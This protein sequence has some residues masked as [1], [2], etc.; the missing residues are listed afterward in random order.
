MVPHVIGEG[1]RRRPRGCCVPVGPPGHPPDRI[2]GEG[3]HVRHAPGCGPV[4]HGGTLS[5]EAVPG[6]VG[7]RPEGDSGRG[8]S[9]GRQRSR[10]GHLLPR[11]RH[12]AG[13]RECEV[14][15]GDYL[16]VVHRVGLDR[17]VTPVV[18]EGFSGEW[19]F[20]LRA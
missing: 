12:V 17:R 18:V 20:S 14:G 8:R 15:V 9:V 16:A 10:N 6:V 13:E 4:P 3:H 2:V 7:H 1:L 5:R 11:G 19:S